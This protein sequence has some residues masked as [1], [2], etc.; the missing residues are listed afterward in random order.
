M[1]TFYVYFESKEAIFRSL[2]LHM[3]RLT[4][5]WIAERVVDA[6]DRLTA[7]QIGIET[8][9]EFARLHK[10]LYRIVEE[11]QFVAPDAFKAHYDGFAKAYSR[12]LAA[13]EERGEVSP[14]DAEQ[15]AWALIGISVF[16]GLRYALWDDSKPV[17][18]VAKGA[19]DLIRHGLEPKAEDT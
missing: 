11:S 10:N 19:L 7:E 18:E 17:P 14:G 13:A 15:R 4:R 5:T 12:N 8:Y 1:G 3:S 9:L 6:P 16:L 2:V